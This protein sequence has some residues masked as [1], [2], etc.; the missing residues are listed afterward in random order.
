M[1]VLFCTFNRHSQSSL[2]TVNYIYVKLANNPINT[3]QRS[4]SIFTQLAPA[5]GSLFKTG[6]KISNNIKKQIITQ[7]KLKCK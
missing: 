1:V 7:L 5:Q 4:P 2:I 3:L 6:A